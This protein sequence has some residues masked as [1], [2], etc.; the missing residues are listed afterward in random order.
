MHVLYQFIALSLHFFDP[1]PVAL[2]HDNIFAAYCTI[3]YICT[4][5][6]SVVHSPFMMDSLARDCWNLFVRSCLHESVVTNCCCCNCTCAWPHAAASLELTERDLQ[7]SLERAFLRWSKLSTYSVCSEGKSKETKT[8]SEVTREG[9]FRWW[10]MSPK[11]VCTW[12]LFKRVWGL[13]LRSF[14]ATSFGQRGAS[15]EKWIH[16]IESTSKKNFLQCQAFIVVD[17]RTWL[18]SILSKIEINSV[19]ISWAKL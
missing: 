3:E 1:I 10:L 2:W 15:S 12:G 7:G 16:V 13:T 18:Y 5:S 8:L 4:D 11:C 19:V 6:W 14:E 17:I 9:E